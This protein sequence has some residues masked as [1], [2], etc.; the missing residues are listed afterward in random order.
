MI[1]SRKRK[2]RRHRLQLGPRS[3]RAATISL[4]LL[5]RALA[6]FQSKHPVFR[7]MAIFFLLIGGF[8]VTAVFPW[9]QR[10]VLEPYLQFTAGVSAAVLRR[11][12][13]T[14]TVRG[15]ILEGSRFSLE[16]RAGCDALEPS[17]LFAAA[18]LAFP[19]PLR[20]KLN[21]LLGGI[22]ALLTINV[23]RIL[24]LYYTGVYRPSY[25]TFLHTSVWQPLFILLV[26]C[27][28]LLWAVQVAPGR[29]NAGDERA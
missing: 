27:F 18:V 28:W 12:G 5:R 21:A 11:W 23:A 2:R 1:D 20:R 13:D 7:F 6:W 14:A 15:A 22:S 17:A 4:P 9:Y 25:L 8:Y 16:V 10:E 3:G 26:A 24:S 19:A 29:T